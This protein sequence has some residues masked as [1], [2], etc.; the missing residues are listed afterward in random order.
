MSP[1]ILHVNF[2]LNVPCAE[3]EEIAHL[4]IHGTLPNRDELDAY[5]YKLKSLRGLPASLLLLPE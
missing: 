4:L 5:K 3:Y 1:Q 2:R